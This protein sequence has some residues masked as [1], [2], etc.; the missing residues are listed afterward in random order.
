MIQYPIRVPAI[1]VTQPLGTF[2]AA[3][4][5]VELLLET[6]YSEK[7]QAQRDSSG[8]YVIEGT[9]RLQKNDRLR[10]IA[11][12]INREDSTF[13][14]SIILAANY[15]FDGDVEGDSLD[16]EVEFDEQKNRWRIE[17]DTQSTSS[18]GDAIERLVLVIPSK[19]RIAAVIDGQHR[20]FAFTKAHP[21]HLKDE[22]LCA[23]FMDLPKPMQAQI[24]AVINSTQK[25]VNKSLTYD[26][27]GYNVDDEEEQYWSPEK[28]A[29]FFARRLAVSDD[30][31]LKNRIVVAPEN[32]FASARELRKMPWKVSFAT[33]VRGVLRLVSSN[34]KLDA[35][36]L[37]TP[38][39]PRRE[40]PGSRSN[41]KSVL[42]KY[43]LDVND[44]LIYDAVQNFTKAANNVFWLNVPDD[45]YIKKTIGVQALLDVM[46]DLVGEGLSK[47]DLSVGFFEGYLRKAKHINFSDDRFRNFSGSGRGFIRRLLQASLGL[48]Y[49]GTIS[50]DDKRHFKIS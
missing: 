48:A 23:V 27:F 29:V 44:K 5:P 36:L 43:Y 2:F 41:D 18:E 28:L 14:N 15:R 40:G 19:K 30:S 45:S 4:I 1:R 42:R 31:P 38:R 33:V 7:V 16:E 50:S 47:L 13:P 20:L 6:S 26:L 49:T 24:F 39:Q 35:S 11:R 17:A 3:A 8:T 32:T 34:P 37:M 10:E 21:E 9:Q 22:L 46:C 12:F 25:P